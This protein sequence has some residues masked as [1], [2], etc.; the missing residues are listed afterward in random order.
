MI[1]NYSNQF[2]SKVFFPITEAQ[3]TTLSPNADQSA[4]K[5]YPPCG[6]TGFIPTDCKNLIIKSRFCSRSAAIDGK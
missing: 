1:K 5:K 6:T 4:I 3:F 2:N